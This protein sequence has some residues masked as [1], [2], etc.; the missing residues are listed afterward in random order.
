MGV[1]RE[2]ACQKVRRIG[3][4]VGG[5]GGTSFRGRAEGRKSVG[6]LRAAI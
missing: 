6:R 5:G 4:G 2:I 3:Y 1:G